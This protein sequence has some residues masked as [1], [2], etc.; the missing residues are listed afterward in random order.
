MMFGLKLKLVNVKQMIELLQ[1][2]EV[3]PKIKL[4]RNAAFIIDAKKLKGVC[5]GSDNRS[6]SDLKMFKR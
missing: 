4:I 2:Q 3:N 6:R 5:M 1:I